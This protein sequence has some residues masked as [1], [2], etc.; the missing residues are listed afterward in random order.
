VL[1]PGIYDLGAPLTLRHAGQ[2]LLGLGMAT[3]VAPR[4][5]RPC[6]AVAPGV[7]GVR[8]AG[9]MLQASSLDAD[10]P[11]VCMCTTVPSVDSNVMHLFS[12]TEGVLGR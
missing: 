8:V 11:E 12:G 6:V 5:G 9:L 10:L 4:D 1:A 7:A 3:L 2:V